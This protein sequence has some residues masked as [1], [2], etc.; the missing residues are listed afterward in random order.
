MGT[1]GWIIP[2]ALQVTHS[3]TCRRWLHFPCPN[4]IHSVK[5]YWK[6]HC[7]HSPAC[8]NVLGTALI[9]K[10]FSHQES[11]EHN[12]VYQT[13]QSKGWTK[14]TIQ[15]SS[16]TI[17]FFSLINYTRSNINN[18]I[19]CLWLWIRRFLKH[20][21]QLYTCPWSQSTARGPLPVL[22]PRLTAET[23]HS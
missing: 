12:L 22:L 2:W 7:N 17:L 16:L 11:V 23:N 10:M 5:S 1:P 20:S 6:H 18:D 9:P 21:K 14:P 13:A 15:D 4:S 8:S 3:L 19:F